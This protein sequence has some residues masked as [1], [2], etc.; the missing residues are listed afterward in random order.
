[1]INPY[2]STQANLQINEDAHERMGLFFWGAALGAT[3]LAFGLGMLGT[4]V[5]PAFE[6]IFVAFGADLPA[7]SLLILQG[8]FLLWLAFV[9]AVAIWLFW[10]ISPS[11]YQLR[12]R[13][14]KAFLLLG[15]ACGCLYVLAA[16]ALYS[17]I[18]ALGRAV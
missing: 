7:Q 14:A 12:R 11:R 5:V 4:F 6:E 13:I 16:W 1:M 2:E 3:F 8:R 18:M 10:F 15:V 9:S 17:P